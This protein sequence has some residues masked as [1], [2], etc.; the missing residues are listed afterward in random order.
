M[1]KVCYWDADAKAQR[2]RD[3]TPAEE[4]QRLADIAEAT[5]TVPQSVPKLN[6]RLALIAAGYWTDVVAFVAEQGEVALA[7]LE[8]AQTMRRDNQLVNAWAAARGKTDAE[9]DALFIA[10][11]LLG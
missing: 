9:V 3:M 7:Y 8:D 1:T 2:E 11:A 5:S 6:A 4:T 10:A